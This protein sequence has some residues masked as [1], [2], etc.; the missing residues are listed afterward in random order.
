MLVLISLLVVA[1]FLLYKYATKNWSYF[2]DRD[3]AYLKPKFLIGSNASVFFKQESMP[4]FFKRV[5]LENVD[6]K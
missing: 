1:A 2:K 6:K 4:D 5:Y 3:V